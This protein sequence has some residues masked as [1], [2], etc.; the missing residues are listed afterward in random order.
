MHVAVRSALFVPPAQSMEHLMNHDAFEVTSLAKGDVLW[1]SHSA[2][3]GET[4][5]CVCMP[6]KL[7]FATSNYR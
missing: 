5:V 7:M 6:Q 3:E 2:N 4:P 1:A